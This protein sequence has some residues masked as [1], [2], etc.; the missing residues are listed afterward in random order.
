MLLE[1]LAALIGLSLALSRSLAADHR[2]GDVTYDAMG[3]LGI[4]VLL[5]IVAVVLAVEMRSLLLGEAAD[6]DVQRQ[7]ADAIASAPNVVRL[8]H[9]PDRAPR[10]R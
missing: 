3:S 6:P 4:G 7:I 2:D 5:A 9:L 10:P 8:I 1:D